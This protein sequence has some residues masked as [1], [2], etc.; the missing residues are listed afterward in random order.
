MRRSTSLPMLP[1]E[2]ESEAHRAEPA[3]DDLLGVVAPDR[4]YLPAA[5]RHS[6]QEGKLRDGPTA[7]KRLN[8]LH[9]R[10]HLA[11]AQRD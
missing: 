2:R 10:R 4:Y 8:Q 7:A 3:A 5:W 1:A 11:H 6:L 9:R